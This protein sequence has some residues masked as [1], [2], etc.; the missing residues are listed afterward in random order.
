[1]SKKVIVFLEFHTHEDTSWFYQNIFPKLVEEL[2]YLDICEEGLR[3]NEIKISAGEILQE[4]KNSQSRRDRTRLNFKLDTEQKQQLDYQDDCD[5]INKQVFTQ[6][7]QYSKLKFHPFDFELVPG[8][9]LINANQGIRAL[10]T[11]PDLMEKILPI[12]NHA[13]ANNI[14]AARKVCEN[15]LLVRM[16]LQHVGIQHNLLH[17][18]GEDIGRHYQFIYLYKTGCEGH[19]DIRIKDGRWQDYFPLGL[20][21]ID[22]TDLSAQQVFEKIKKN[23]ESKIL[24][25]PSISRLSKKMQAQIRPQIQAATPALKVLKRIYLVRIA[26][27]NFV[28]DCHKRDILLDSNQVFQLISSILTSLKDTLTSVTENQNDVKSI[29]INLA[30]NLSLLKLCHISQDSKFM[31]IFQQAVN[32]LIPE[33]SLHFK[34]HD[35]HKTQLGEEYIFPLPVKKTSY[36]SFWQA[37]A[38]MG[39]AAVAT[40]I[41]VTSQ[42]NSHRSI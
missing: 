9:S 17:L 16:G 36:C 25:K 15:R 4:I 11:R 39:V 26:V 18:Y 34:K 8:D 21:K 24:F 31:P 1:M 10:F 30:K 27:I 28:D 32:K 7:A 5:H 20:L 19:P 40:S 23:L 29:K 2:N 41:L 42:Y 3:G 35:L 37:A 6:Y 13:M 33:I 12:R 14:E 22:Y 38:L